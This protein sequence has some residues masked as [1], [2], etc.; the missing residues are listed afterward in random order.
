LML[1]SAAK[2][3]NLNWFQILNNPKKWITPNTYFLLSVMT[4]KKEWIEQYSYRQW[5]ENFIDKFLISWDSVDTYIG[6]WEK[7]M[8]NMEVENEKE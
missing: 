8:K 2:K 6:S 3:L 4:K 1:N 5:G 7:D